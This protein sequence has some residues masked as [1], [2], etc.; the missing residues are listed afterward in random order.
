MSA[1]KRAPKSAAGSASSGKRAASASQAGVAEITADMLRGGNA[2]FAIAAGIFAAAAMHD[3]VLLGP[4]Q[5][6][7]GGAGAGLRAFDG[8]T[9]Q[10]G[11]GAAR[12]RGFVSRA[13]VPPAARVAVPALPAALAT[14][15]AACG[16]GSL[17]AALGPALDLAPSLS[18][19]RARVLQRFA[20]DGAAAI[21]S[22][23]IAEEL[24]ES[25]GRVA[26]GIVGHED[27]TELR[28]EV[29][30]CTVETI[31]ERRVATAPWRGQGG[32]S[33]GTHVEIIAAADARGLIAIACYETPDEGVAIP[34][35]GLRAP[36]T[37]APVM[38]GETRVRP[39]TPRPAASPIALSESE[40]LV[41]LA[42]GIA[43]HDAAEA[44]FAAL[45]ARAI[46]PMA[47]LIPGV[48]GVARTRTHAR[49]LR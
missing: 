6:L 19:A 24:I 16:A 35:L 4:V 22:K 14:A 31:G 45:L 40:A 11:R 25:A 27:L 44:A 12:P 9:Q 10:P 2:V 42:L 28:P 18:E 3:G 33:S 32:E 46:A 30:S 36:F 48:F 7:V 21:A 23:P 37:A 38:R 41:D 17:K 26:G 1:A 49:A 8:R 39:G 5:I 15:L 13:E 47:E 20:R 43:H 29:A 34:E